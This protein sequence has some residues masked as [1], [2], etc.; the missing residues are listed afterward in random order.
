MG[1]HRKATY[2]LLALAIAIGLSMFAYEHRNPGRITEMARS[3][4]ARL[5]P[6]SADRSRK[7][8]PKPFAGRLKARG[9]EIGQPVVLRLFKEDGELELWMQGGTTFELVATYP[10]CAWSGDLGPKLREGD[11]QS[12]EG[13]YL[14]SRNQLKPDSSYYRAINIGFPNAY[15]KSLGR[16]GSYLMIHGDCVSIGCYAMTDAGIDDIY[17]TVE[18]ALAN[19]QSAIPIHIF[20]FR[21][22]AENFERHKGHRWMEFWENLAEGDRLF[23]TTQLSPSIAACG[24]KYVFNGT[25]SDKSC[26]TIVA[27]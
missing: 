22:T 3:L 8:N 20:P 24:G 23:T 27:W 11:G 26:K 10:I 5:S 1:R 6:D 14:A 18:Q 12:P 2:L 15:D 17:T 13:F 25:G 16:T 21:M 7:L 9:F 19:G 4:A